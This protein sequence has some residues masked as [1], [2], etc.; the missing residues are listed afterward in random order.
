MTAITQETLSVSGILL[1]K[2]FTR[3]RSE[4]DRYADENQNQIALQ[5]KQQMTRPVV[6]RDGEHLHVR[7]SRRSSTSSRAG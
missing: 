5:V 7:R 1:S 6:L 3:Q 2:S 4:I